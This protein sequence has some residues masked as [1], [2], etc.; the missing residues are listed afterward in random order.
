MSEYDV[1]KRAQMI[2]DAE[3]IRLKLKNLKIFRDQI[4]DLKVPRD[5]NNDG[6]AGE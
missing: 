4:K 6:V 5:R 2:N 3:A 1:F